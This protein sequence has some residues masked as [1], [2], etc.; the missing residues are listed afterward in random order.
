[1]NGK[2]LCN[3]MTLE[4]K[5]WFLSGEIGMKTRSLE[6]LGIPAVSLADGPHGVRTTIE[7]N[8]THFPNLCS[9][10]SSWNVD[11][12]RKMGNALADDCIEHNINVLLG[13]GLNVKRH[14]L[15][16]R[17]FEYFSEDPV[18]SGEM[19][20]GYVNGLQEKGVSACAKHFAVN[21]QEEGRRTISAEIDERTLREIYLKAFQVMLEHSSPDSM[22]CAYNKVNGVWCSENPLLMK[23][24]LKK[25]WN[26][27]GMVV[28]DW[29][30]VQNISRAIHAGLDLQEPRNLDIVE[31]LLA[32]IE[33][34]QVTIEEIDDAVMRLLNFVIRDPLPEQSYDRDAQHQI[35]RELAADSIVL[36]K[37]DAEVLPLSPKKYKKITVVGEYAV[38][39]LIGGQG[40]AEVLQS[41]DY[42]DSPLA[43]LQKHLPEI[44]FQYLE[45]YKKD[46]FSHEMLWPKSTAFTEA[47]KDSDLVL[48]FAGSMVSEDT[49]KFDRFTP[50]I[51]PNMDM[52][53]EWAKDAGKK[54]VVVLQNGGALVFGPGL[55]NAEGILEMWLSGEAAGGAI[56]DVL[57]GKVNPS[58]KLTETFPTKLRT[59]LDYPGNGNFLS[60]RERFDVGYRYYGKHPEEIAY[61]FGH[62]LSYT[63]F[64]YSNGTV[65][66]DLTVSVTLK[67][68]GSVAGSEVVQLY[69]GDPDSTVER[70]IKELKKFKKVYLNP[71]EETTVSFSLS[72]MDLAYYNLSLRDWVVENGMYDFY[73]GS[74]SRDIRQKISI[75][76]QKPMPYSICHISN[77][78]IG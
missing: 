37:N 40:S 6:R 69:I 13:P 47:I 23:E 50:S 11:T 7:K 45:M 42:I 4:E 53:I 78:M 1:M 58:G 18:L 68:T 5:L 12:A 33:K 46:G 31:Q 2:E 39:P 30:A 36:L 16:G 48:Y 49:E 29:G 35:A 22:M 71:G 67:N 9:L 44:E 70:P 43:E 66:E 21:S 60:Y 62:G 32:G 65:S 10:G 52:T 75:D 14:I 76:Y 64:E 55:K 56:A 63:S 24:I 77:D 8:C 41:P 34:G 73:I 19:A 54:A 61:P 51:N 15:C 74:S 26:Y 17:N 28:S 38:S 27:E 20:A 72:P 25:E 3:A 59:D 57:C